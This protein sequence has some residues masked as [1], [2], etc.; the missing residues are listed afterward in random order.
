MPE[1]KMIP[2]R[3][4]MLPKP[5]KTDPRWP[6]LFSVMVHDVRTPVTVVA[7]YVDMLLKERFGPLNDK[8]R[9]ILEEVHKSCGRVSGLLN[10]GSELTSIERQNVSMNRRPADLR[11]ILRAAIE[12]LPPLPDREVHVELQTGSGDASFEADPP[13]L[14]NAFTALLAGLR[15]EV[16]TTNRLLVREQRTREGFEIRVGDEETLPLLDGASIP[17]LP[18]FDEWRGG[19]GMTLAIARRV[20][21]AHEGHIVGAPDGRKTGALVVLRA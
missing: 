12:Q 20:F 18:V 7:G 5:K 1:P 15:R 13:R 3:K 21:N 17:D 8:Q 9:H 10:E 2:K 14:T 19:V 16:V 6:D 11:A 4:K